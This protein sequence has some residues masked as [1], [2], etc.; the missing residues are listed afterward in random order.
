[1]SYV[2]N[3][4]DGNI[5]AVVE[6]GTIDTIS[7]SITLVGKGT[8]NY[9]EYIAENQVVMLENFANETDP[10]YPLKG[11]LWFD[12]STGYI[13]VFDGTA[14]MS[15][16]TEA[17]YSSS[18]N[19]SGTGAI[20]IAN[21]S[22]ITVGASSTAQLAFESGSAVLKTNGS[23]NAFTINPS[24][25]AV[26]VAADP[27]ADLGIATKQ[28]V[29]TIESFGVDVNNRAT[30]ASD[31]YELK[32]DSE[33]MIS[34]DSTGVTLAGAS[35][36][37]N[38]PSTETNDLQIASTAF[39][40]NNKVSPAFT[41]TPTAPTASTLTNT[42]QLATTA[43]VQNNKV[44]PAFSGTPTT[45]TAAPGTNT[46]QIA[47]TEFV[48]DAITTLSSTASATYAP[49][50]TP[51]FTGV[52]AAPTASVG[53]NTTQLASTA[54]VQSQLAAD[55]VSPAFSGTPTAP[56]AAEG[57][58]TT[59]IASTSYV[60]TATEKWGG[61]KKFVSTSDPTSGD[62]VDGDFWFKIV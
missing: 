33:T 39:V 61:S 27:T 54:F 37:T 51:T 34:A 24:T 19:T 4:T 21:N 49:I 30:I 44:G 25:G 11:Q 28:Y 50:N 12:T 31:S 46:T 41:G 35:Y 60:M 55:K 5:V 40:Q 32:L 45:P 16:V 13:K 36:V 48:T 22:G 47:S 52:P 1:M 3:K 56:K 15:P 57:T 62:G 58:N 10:A 59:Q 7:T 8:Q 18:S 38:T 26:T 42:T 53:T 29:D 17:Y 20:T 43:F 9:G 6:D 23:V 2:V 14:W